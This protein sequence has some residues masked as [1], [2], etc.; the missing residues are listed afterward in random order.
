MIKIVE[1]V[2]VT[3]L[4]ATAVAMI[5]RDTLPYLQEWRRSRKNG[6]NNAYARNFG[7][8]GIAVSLLLIFV[9]VCAIIID[10]S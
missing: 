2:L 7:F 6:V 3:L 9:L 10:F 8:A 5:V 1:W 4:A